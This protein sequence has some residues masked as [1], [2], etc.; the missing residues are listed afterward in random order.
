MLVICELVLRK[1]DLA[2]RPASAYA[3]KIPGTYA[4]KISAAV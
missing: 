2:S 4:A 1:P 3:A